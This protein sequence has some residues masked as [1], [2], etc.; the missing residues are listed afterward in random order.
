MSQQECVKLPTY[1]YRYD[2]MYMTVYICIYTQCST[3]A[4]VVVEEEKKGTLT[5]KTPARNFMQCVLS[6]Y[7]YTE[8]LVPAFGI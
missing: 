4:K 6:I 3:L 7:M 8:H 5:L 1:M 2:I